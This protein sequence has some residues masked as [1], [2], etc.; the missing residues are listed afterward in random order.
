M[1]STN[2]SVVR[3]RVVTTPKVMDSKYLVIFVWSILSTL[4]LSLASCPPM[5]SVPVTSS[6]TGEFV[7]ALSWPGYG[8]NA[9]EKAD[10][11]HGAWFKD[12]CELESSWPH[13]ENMTDFFE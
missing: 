10:E 1:I 7:A 13:G 8:D 9:C 3:N 5:S 11:Y 12:P 6:E 4:D 2:L